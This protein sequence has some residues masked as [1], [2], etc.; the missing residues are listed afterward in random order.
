MG[1]AHQIGGAIRA[2]LLGV[3]DAGRVDPH[4]AWFGAPPRSTGFQPVPVHRGGFAG[5]DYRRVRMKASSSLRLAK[6]IRSYQTI[7]SIALF[8][9]SP[10]SIMIRV[11]TITPWI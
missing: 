5:A 11:P 9:F 8:G 1:A 6:R 2:T 4:P 7:C 3:A 10:V